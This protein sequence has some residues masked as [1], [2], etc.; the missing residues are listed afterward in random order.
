[1]SLLSF[2]VDAIYTFR[3]LKLLVTP[4]NKMKAFELGLIDENGKRIKEK[5]VTNSEERD[6]FTTFHRLVFNL[7]RLLGKVPGGKTRLAS[8]ASALFLLKEK[9]N[10]SDKSLDKILKESGYEPI[11]ILEEAST[12]FILE[13]DIMSPGV[14][15]M[16]DGDKLLNHNLAEAVQKG[17]KVRVEKNAAPVGD[18]FGVNIYEVTHMNTNKNIYITAAEVLR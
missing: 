10:L 18:V 13:N 1:M 14:Y 8:Y 17:D 12:W 15:R 7:K 6:S 9:Y 4:F 2:G 3:F 11:D 5:K 16:R